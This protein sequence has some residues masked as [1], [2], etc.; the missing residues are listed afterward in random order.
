MPA[1]KTTAARGAMKS[2]QVMGEG[3]VNDIVNKAIRDAIRTQARELE[4]F[5]RDID[6]RLTALE[7]KR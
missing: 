1:R 7:E 4:K 6:E 5:F 2:A 3:A